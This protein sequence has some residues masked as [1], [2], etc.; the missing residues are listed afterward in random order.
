[1]RQKYIY[2]PISICNSRYTAIT[3][4]FNTL[5]IPKCPKMQVHSLDWTADEAA[6]ALCLEHK[7]RKKA[8]LS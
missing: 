5:A 6:F 1:M 7:E 2:G 4:L 8:S 3:L